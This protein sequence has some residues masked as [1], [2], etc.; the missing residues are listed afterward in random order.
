MRKTHAT[1]NFIL[2][3]TSVETKLG[4][5]IAIADDHHLYLLAFANRRGL[6]REVECLRKKLSAVIIPGTTKIIKQITDELH[7]YFEGKNF[8]FKTPLKLLGSPF[9]KNVWEAL[10]KIPK[11]ETRSYLEIS[12]AIKN[13]KAFR[14]VANANGANQ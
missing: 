7:N 8:I 1:N 4:P 14:A 10:L 2:K 6:E 12:K 11:G 9:Q 5:M 13:P 3:T